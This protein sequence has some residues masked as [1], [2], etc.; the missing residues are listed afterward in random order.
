[1]LVEIK[2]YDQFMILEML[3][4]AKR[5][6]DLSGVVESLVG[7]ADE[8]N[9]RF[10]AL[11][12]SILPMLQSEDTP[13]PL[14]IVTEMAILII[15]KCT[16][17]SEEGITT[18]KYILRM[19][20][21]IVKNS[22]DK[23]AWTSDEYK[24]AAKDAMA[25]LIILVKN[26]EGFSDNLQQIIRMTEE[27]LATPQDQ[28]TLSRDY[29]LSQAETSEELLTF[30]RKVFWLVNPDK[31]D[32][33]YVTNAPNPSFWLVQEEHK[34]LQHV[35]KILL[36]IQPSWKQVNFIGSYPDGAI[37]GVTKQDLQDTI[38]P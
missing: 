11:H 35:K 17:S 23:T 21:K 29:M 14:D 3:V 24:I 32:Y 31:T 26:N 13:V 7:T 36:Q 19:I 6:I 15:K 18:L 37:T 30:A 4:A 12:L 33:S 28:I 9:I 25:L 5:Q 10:T 22:Q 8:G 1:M 16:E 2:A 34:D 38:R 27:I 20:H